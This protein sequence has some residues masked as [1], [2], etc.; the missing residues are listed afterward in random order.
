MRRTLLIAGPGR[1]WDTWLSQ[2]SGSDLIC[3]DSGDSRFGPAGKV[4]HTRE[5]RV[6]GGFF[7]GT[8]DV[9]RG[10]H[11]LMAGLARLLGGA[12]DDLVIQAFPYS[13]TPLA[14]QTLQLVAEV[15]RPDEIL[16]S[17]SLP[18]RSEG[19]PCPV[20]VVDLPEEAAEADLRVSQR[21]AQWLR[22]RERGALHELDLSAVTIR[23]ARLGSGHRVD[24]G[25]WSLHGVGGTAYGELC[26]SVLFV[27][28]NA[29]PEEREVMRVLDYFHC[30]R[31]QM[32]HAEDYEGL[33]CAFV[34]PG[35]E[36]FGFGTLESLDFA[37]FHARVWS[38]AV[39][40]V[41]VPILDFGLLRVDA[42]GREKPEIRAWQL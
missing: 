28:G 11:R 36:E 26:G 42:D 8:L 34:R 17:P 2:R 30:N 6:H 24:P 3:L 20:A 33:L 22:L 31:L 25:E 5:G 32:A 14:R 18:L 15:I 27:V 16:M 39:P 7:M 21:K 23:G 4:W 29:Q 35:G 9:L 38:D 1:S 13:E 37:S 40:P 10:P 19:W 12:S 41:P